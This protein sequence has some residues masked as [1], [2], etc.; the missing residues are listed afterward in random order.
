MAQRSL[1][2][3][4]ACGQ[5]SSPR[6][7]RLKIKK[8]DKKFQPKISGDRT[9]ELLIQNWNAGIM[10][11]NTETW[12]QLNDFLFQFIQGKLIE[13]KFYIFLKQVFFLK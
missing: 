1:L 7:Y 2:N 11:N 12:S 3:V 5:V 10:D 4:F 13:P 9:I 8:G 6:L